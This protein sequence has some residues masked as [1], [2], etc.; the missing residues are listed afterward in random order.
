MGRDS[1]AHEGRGRGRGD[2]KVS[3][4]SDEALQTALEHSWRI[5]PRINGLRRHFQVIFG[6]ILQ[7]WCGARLAE[8]FA[9]TPP[10]A[11]SALFALF[12]PQTFVRTPSSTVL[13]LH[14]PCALSC[15]P[16]S[17]MVFPTGRPLS[18]ILD[19]I[20]SLLLSLSLSR[21]GNTIFD[22][23]SPFVASLSFRPLFPSFL[24]FFCPSICLSVFLANPH[25]RF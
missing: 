3:S 18:L 25:L 12:I 15:S 1:S 13:S 17:L 9:S 2:E 14:T 24:F 4:F 6:L 23:S 19:S 16:I 21:I 10:Q 5:V 11:L 8:T 20:N 22:C 7:G